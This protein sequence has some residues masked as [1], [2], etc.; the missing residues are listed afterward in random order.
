MPTTPPRA[1][2]G[3]VQHPLLPI[4]GRA[5]RPQVITAPIIRNPADAA[6]A[7][8]GL[9]VAKS[10]TA[11]GQSVALPTENWRYI[12]QRVLTGA[13]LDRVG[14]QMS[15]VTMTWDLVT[16]Q[17]QGSISP[18]DFQRVAPD[19]LPLFDEWS[20][21]IYA[22]DET[23]FIHWGGLLVSSSFTG[24]D[25]T[26]NC[27]GFR[28][29]A[30]G[31]IYT[32]PEYIQTSVDPLD[33]VRYVWSWLQAQP[34]GNIGLIAD[35]T[36]SGTSVGSAASPYTLAWYDANDCGQEITN[37][38]QGTPFDLGEVHSWTDASQASVY[39]R[40][41]L[42]WPRIGTRQLGLRFVEGENIT[43]L[44]DA[45]RDGS[46]Y[47]NEMSGIG[48][49]TGTTAIRTFL[50]QPDPN[51]LRRCGAFTDQTISDQGQLAVASQRAM[52]ALV[53]PLQGQINS[54]SWMNH[55]NA[56]LGSFHA[57]DDILVQIA[58]GWLAGQRIWH[59]VVSVTYEP[60]TR[61]GTLTMA[62]SDSYTY[63]PETFITGQQAPAGGLLLDMTGDGKPDLVATVFSPGTAVPGDYT[64]ATRT[65][66]I[67]PGLGGVNGLSTF[68]SPE[69][70]WGPGWSGFNVVGVGDIHNSGRNGLLVVNTWN[71]TLLFYP[72]NPGGGSVQPFEYVG[73]GFTTGYRIIGLGK[74]FGERY[75]GLLAIDPSGFIIYYPGIGGTGTN[76]FA[77]SS[78]HIGQNWSLSYG[79]SVADFT[80]D[81]WPDLL[82]VNPDG[83]LIV[84]PNVPGSGYPGTGQFQI[85]TG[86][87]GYQF[88]GAVFLSGAA[89][90]DVIAVDPLGNVWLYPNSGGTALGNR[91]LVGQGFEGIAV[92]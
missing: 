11:I 53:S 70:T 34:N 33:A 77:P 21:A 28:G 71:S 72:V 60:A 37:L 18:L 39:H 40:L 62:R 66:Y 92:D 45:V 59:R 84:I 51:R 81:G 15:A 17:F 44:V 30:A 76:T 38:A 46:K 54:C 83:S 87:E 10:V 90:C 4:L 32:G 35:G 52:Q 55:P 89:G 49:G 7:V 67:Y 3:P 79:M 61:S 75:P 27:I 43:A 56:P 14:A 91:V 2:Q 9:V 86:F 29:Y 19:G 64:N 73:A 22:I 26:L 16:D 85:G 23:G 57:G 65:V 58:N 36:R 1:R 78:F 47:S 24:P 68:G 31:N 12:A 88:V 8:E 69:L 20:T 5:G 25:W 6:G 48:A 42:G 63:G 50:G 13:W 82:I 41:V 74:V 80:G